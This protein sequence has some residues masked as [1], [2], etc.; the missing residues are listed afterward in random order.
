MEIS[1]VPVGTGTTSVSAYVAGMIKRL[2]AREAKFQ[3]GPMGTIVEGD[4]DE[5]LEIAKELHAV[6]FGMGALRVLTTIKIDDRRDKPLSAEG[7]V[8]SVEEKLR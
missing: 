8:R 2:K 7:K 4:M 3:L 6:P 1:V 5:L